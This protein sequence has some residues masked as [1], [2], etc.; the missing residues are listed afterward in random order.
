MSEIGRIT[1]QQV[2]PECGL[3]GRYNETQGGLICR[4]GQFS[5]ELYDITVYHRRQKL[6]ITHD[7]LGRRI[8]GYRHARRILEVIRSRDDEG[9]FNPQEWAGALSN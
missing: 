1:S 2:C 7:H 8:D 5:P 9:A 3:R 4:C 6:R